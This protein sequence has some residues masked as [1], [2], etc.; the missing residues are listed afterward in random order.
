VAQALAAAQPPWSVNAAAQAAGLAALM[1]DEHV[2]RGRTV[3]HEA[4]AH[5]ARGLRALGLTPLPSAANYC[6]VE[7][8]DAA[9]VAAALR[10]RGIWVRDCTSFGLPRHVRVAARPL[11]ECDALLAALAHVLPPTANPDRVEALA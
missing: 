8:P 2:A 1:Q 11:P 3:A 5:L 7:V 6:L 4:L 10:A 9:R